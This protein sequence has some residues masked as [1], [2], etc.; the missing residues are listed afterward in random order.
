MSGVEDALAATLRIS[1]PIVFAVLGEIVV[2]RSGVLNLG[3]E[4][5]M[6]FGAFGGAVGAMSMG[7]PW[8]GAVLGV[9]LAMGAAALSALLIVRLNQDAILV[10]VGVNLL[11]VGVTG[12]LSR[13]LTAQGTEN[14]VAPLFPV[15]PL[16]FF[17]HFPFLGPT[18]FTQNALGFLAILLTPIIAWF[19]SSTSPGLFVRAAGESPEALASLGVRVRWLRSG[20]LLFGGA[21]AGLAGVYLSVGY[22]DTFVENMSAGRGFIALAIVV[23]ARWNAW[24]GMCGAL[25]FAGT[26]ALQA[27]LQ[28]RLLGGVE[29]PYHAF[30]MLPYLATLIVL[31]VTPR[32]RG[33][34]PASLGRPFHGSQR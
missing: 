2:Q 22:S 33:R 24:G 28:G 29:I 9:A 5:M 32:A 26:M 11:A 15:I 8:G 18:L 6:L 3:I 14:L 20:A 31:A 27:R 1:I 34:A 21:M 19:L 25:F 16:P 12:V 7:N 23:L 10:G 30:Q 4:G 17:H 13:V